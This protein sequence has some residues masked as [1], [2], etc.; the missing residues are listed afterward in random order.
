MSALPNPLPLIGLDGIVLAH[1][2]HALREQAVCAMAS[3]SLFLAESLAFITAQYPA[4][5]KR[6]HGANY[7]HYASGVATSRS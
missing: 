2:G 3:Q 5:R 1:G 7:E 6:R 4:S